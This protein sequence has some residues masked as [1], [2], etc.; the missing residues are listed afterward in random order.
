MN[1]PHDMGGLHGFGPVMPDP[2]DVKFHADW[3]R[4]AMAIT[5]AAGA[6]GHWSIDESRHAREDRPH[7]EYLGLTYYALWIAALERLLLRHGLI[8]EAELKAGHA[9]EDTTPPKRVLQAADVAAGL[10]RGAP[11]NRDPGDAT[12][13]FAPGD[14]VHTRNLQPRGHVRLPAYARDKPGRITAVHGFHVLPDRSAVGDEQADWLYAVTFSAR[15]L[16]GAS[17]QEGDEVT[18]DAWEC[19]LD[20][21]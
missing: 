10:A 14:A 16:F 20:R 21:A 3:E 9:L 8:T 18:I 12:P 2:A 17:A 4:R 15:D 7:A 1:G 11:A 6:G 13:A 5:V 19:Y